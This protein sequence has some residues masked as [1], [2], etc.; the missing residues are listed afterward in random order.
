MVSKRKYNTLILLIL[1]VLSFERSQS[2]HPSEF[3][4]QRIGLNE[5][6]SQSRII[7]IAQDSVGFLWFATQDGLNRYDGYEFKVFRHDDTDSTSISSNYVTALLV[8]NNGD[9]LVG[10]RYGGLNRYGNSQET[11]TQYPSRLYGEIDLKAIH[12]T[13]LVEDTEGL[14]WIATRGNGL[15]C[16]EPTNEIISHYHFDPNNPTSLSDN[17]VRNTALD[18]EGNLWI[19]TVNGLNRLSVNHDQFIRY[20]HDPS[21]PT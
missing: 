10:T 4:F 12:I 21:E 18:L 6:L 15:F 7:D 14:I 5:G 16:L 17:Y 9:L 3:H 13:S 11:F 19:A 8:T 20:R 2:Q 1:T